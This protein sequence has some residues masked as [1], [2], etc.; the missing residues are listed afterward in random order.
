MVRWG[1]EETEHALR[2]EES[3]DVNGK[4][5]RC[6]DGT[7]P[8]NGGRCCVPRG[9]CQKLAMPRGGGGGGGNVD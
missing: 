1:A 9:K 5:G 7:E 6:K 8:C 2:G 4:E 3:V